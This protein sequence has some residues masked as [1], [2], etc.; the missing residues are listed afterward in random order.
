MAA[1]P[2]LPPDTVRYFLPNGAFHNRP[3]PFAQPQID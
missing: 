2:T 3:M 1:N